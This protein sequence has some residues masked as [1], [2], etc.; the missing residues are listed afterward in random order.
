MTELERL[1]AG[2]SSVEIWPFITYV[3]CQRALHLGE[4]AAMLGR[5][6]IIRKS[7]EESAPQA[8]GLDLVRRAEADLL[9]AMGQGQRAR[10]LIERLGPPAATL[11]VPVARVSLL[12][13]EYERAQETAARCIDDARTSARDRLELLLIQAVAT[14]RLGDELGAAA[15]FGEAMVVYRGTGIRRVFKTIPVA[16]LERLLELSGA[17]LAVGDG[18]VLAVHRVVYPQRA[19]VI[20]LTKREQALALELVRS[21]SRQEIADALFVSVNTVK[22]QLRRLYQKFETTTREQT[23]MRLREHGLLP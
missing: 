19:V 10:V 6:A 23:L 9:I 8:A 2:V 5:L 20:T 1:E 4:P 14:L 22:S 18:A 15:V 12:A 13:G 16:E 17:E 7:R 3:L 11:M 21:G